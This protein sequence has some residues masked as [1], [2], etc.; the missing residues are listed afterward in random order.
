MNF[1]LLGDS[2]AKDSG[3]PFHALDP[4][5][6]VADR[7]AYYLFDSDHYPFLIENM[8]VINEVLA[9][10][11]AGQVDWIEIHNR[12]NEMTDI[13][14]WFLSDDGGDLTKFCISGARNAEQISLKKVF[15]N[16]G[17]GLHSYSMKQDLQCRKP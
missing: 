13:S 17:C 16:R 9:N 4:D 12:S 7:G 3:D 10:S 15:K 8:I 5:A 2:I 14:G 1:S 11:G 6:T